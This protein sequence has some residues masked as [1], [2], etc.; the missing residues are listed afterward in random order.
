MVPLAIDFDIKSPPVGAY[1]REI[2][3]V[4]IETS[5]ALDAAQPHDRGS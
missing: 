1:Q 4:L 2:K 5:C 3:I